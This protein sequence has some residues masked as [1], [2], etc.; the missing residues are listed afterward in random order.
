VFNCFKP[1]M[2]ALRFTAIIFIL[3]G[4]VYSLAMV[5]LAQGLFPEQAQGSLIY[6]KGQKLPVGS[7]L[8]GQ[9]FT[10]PQYFHPR[11]STSQYD[12]TQSGGSNLGPSNRQL[13]Q[14]VNQRVSAYQKENFQ[15]LGIPVAK[16]PGD[17]V[18]AS[19]SGLD[20]HISVENALLQ[21]PRIT[22]VR[23]WNQA[24]V[25]IVSSLLSQKSEGGMQS[26]YV[27]V[28]EMNLLIDSLK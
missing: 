12:A 22:K 21:L 5:S 16:I 1:M 13:V 4:F 15:D 9:G 2:N 10:Q 17:A 19:A 27:S 20:P 26:S 11:P 23:H 8:V 25:E 3:V 28:L 18:S 7:R 24:Q 6:K 14:T